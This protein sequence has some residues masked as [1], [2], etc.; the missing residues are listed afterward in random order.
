MLPDIEAVTDENPL[1][2]VLD[3]TQIKE[4][5]SQQI[6]NLLYLIYG[7][8]GLSIII[9]ALGVVNT[10]ALSVLERTREIGLLRAVGASRRQV[11]RMIRWEAVLVAFT[12]ALVGV[13]IGL[14]A[15]VALRQ[16]LSG[17]GIDVLVIPIVTVLVILSLAIVLGILAAAL[18]AR[19]AARLDI[20][21]AIATE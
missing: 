21:E 7:M 9:A 18:P 16:A 13:L 19:R 12:G 15:G 4:Q 3:Q 17:D 20:L 1:L 5:N 2:Q 8:L 6:D 14:I 11:R 10:M